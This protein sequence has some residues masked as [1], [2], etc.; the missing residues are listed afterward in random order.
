MKRSSIKIVEIC[1]WIAVSLV[2]IILSLISGSKIPTAAAVNDKLAH[3]AAY[4]VLGFL[5]FP[6]VQRLN[7]PRTENALFAGLWSFSY[8][9]F[10]GGVLELLQQFT[11][12][13]PD[14]VDFTADAGGAFIGI[15]FSWITL[16]IYQLYINGS[17]PGVS[18]KKRVKR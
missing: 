4:A 1:L 12:R 7:L 18:Q 9:I 11:G 5:S 17:I 3:L 15:S 10:I 16:R 14:I 2:I 8:C 6:A 13:F